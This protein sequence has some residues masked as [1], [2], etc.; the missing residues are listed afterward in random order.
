VDQQAKQE[1]IEAIKSEV[2]E[3]HPLLKSFLGKLPKI[4]RSEYTHGPHE[5]GAD[6]VLTRFDPALSNHSHIG[7][8]AKIG[9]IQQDIS[10]LERQI[11]ECGMKRK[12]NGGR[13]DVRLSEI[14]VVTTSRISNN[15]KDKI[16]DKFSRQRIEFIDGE[17]LT[18]LVDKHASYFWHHIPSPVGTYLQTT[19]DRIEKSNRDL[20]VLS[21]LGCE[22]FFIEPD[23]QEL[24]RTKYLGLKRISKERFLKLEDEALREK[25]LVLEAEMGFGK[26]KTL[27]N[28]AN[29]YC[30]EDKFKHANVLPIFLS[31]RHYVEKY[32]SLEEAIATEL[33]PLFEDVKAQKFRV[34]VTLDG[35]DEAAVLPNWQERVRSTIKDARNIEYANLVLTSRPLHQLD[36]SL[37]LYQGARRLLLRPLSLKKLALFIEKACEKQSIPKKLFADL[38]NSDLFKQLPQS[39][40][41]AAL[42]SRLLSQNQHDL[43]SN[44][45]E[46]YDKSLDLMLGR[47][48]IQKKTATEKDF[49]AARR[50]AALIADFMLRNRLVWMSHAEASQLV[51]DWHNKRNTGVSLD[52]LLQRIFGPDSIFVLNEESKTIAFRHRSFGEFLFA[53]HLASSQASFEIEDA[54]EAYWVHVHFF[55]L[56][57]LGDCPEL[58]SKLMGK[59]PNN[60]IGAWLKVLIMPDYF[61]AGYQTEYRLVEE[62]LY[63]LFI[64]A[65]ELYLRIKRGDT[66]TRLTE[67]PEMHLLWFFQRLIRQ[68]YNYDF[69]RKAITPTILRL[70][71][72]LVDTEVKHIALFFASCF[73]AELDDS[74]G[75]EFMLK[76]YGAEKLPISVSL[77]IQL[78]QQANKDFSKLPLLRDHDRRL[79]AMLRDS[80]LDTQVDKLEKRHSLEDLFE[81]PL[82]ATIGTK[83][84]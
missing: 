52:L 18:V 13:D 16:A 64:E 56:G 6:F 54:F 25:V 61:L 5:K 31:Y 48:D 79:R 33:G 36:E 84:V 8:I 65:S 29:R 60:E 68:C 23:I 57:M 49:L 72:E 66:K 46:L 83:K 42:L 38:Q 12:V 82:K 37:S 11:D 7:V 41:A 14:W 70:E 50:A 19:S 62:N 51:T 58:L 71:Q 1:V 17:Q 55:H 74:N 24:D 53:R 28:L 75:F 40:I 67:L 44:L 43:P 26:S 81:R 32:K 2:N 10:E 22:D 21:D 59:T 78:E 35:I 9:K 63:K 30:A 45:P 3:L 15:A 69:F 20:N 77:A 47:W 76:N 34:L 4:I 80:K 73:A 27:R 39:P